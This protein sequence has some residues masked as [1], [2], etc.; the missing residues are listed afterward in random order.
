MLLVILLLGSDDLLLLV[1]EGMQVV[2]RHLKGAFSEVSILIVNAIH[3][4][5]DFLDFVLAHLDLTHPSTISTNLLIHLILR[6]KWHLGGNLHLSELL[7]HLRMLLLVKLLVLVVLLLDTALRLLLRHAHSRCGLLI[8]FT[9]LL[10]V[11][12][13]V[14]LL[15]VEF[16]R[17]YFLIILLKSTLLFLE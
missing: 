7:L 5:V 6:L 13:V 1:W 8:L 11:H 4:L 10:L 12:L 14:K 9:M 17:V 3:L 2:D 16:L 15:L